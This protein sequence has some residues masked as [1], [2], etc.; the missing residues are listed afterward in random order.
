MQFFYIEPEVAG[1]LGCNTELDTSSHPPKIR[2]LHYVITGWLGDCLL[3]SFPCLIATNEAVE[4]LKSIHVSGVDFEN[5]EI[6]IN[7]DFVLSH[8]NIKIPYFRW[9]KTFGV[10]GEDDFGVA[11][12]LRFVVSERVVNILKDIGISNSLLEPFP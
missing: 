8:P 10:A 7:G 4:L 11:N 1:E 3:E 5:V 6:S 12:D 9:L 2:S